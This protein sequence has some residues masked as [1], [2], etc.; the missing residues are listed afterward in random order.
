MFVKS[1]PEYPTA[2]KM[3]ILTISFSI[4]KIFVEK[5]GTVVGN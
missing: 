3:F 2:A 5:K 1:T 4:I